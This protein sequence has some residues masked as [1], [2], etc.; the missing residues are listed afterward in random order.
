MAA[1]KR[2]ARPI[3]SPRII[4]FTR[5][6]M[7]KRH[8]PDEIRQGVRDAKAA[9]RRRPEAD[10]P[11]SRSARD[12]DERGQG[13]G[14][15]DDD[16][17]R[18]RGDHGEGLHR[19]GRDLDRALLR[20]RRRRARRRPEL[21]GR[22]ELQQRVPSLRAR[23]RTLRAGQPREAPR[24]RRADGQQGRRL[25]PDAVDLRGQPRRDPRAEP[26][27][28]PRLPAPVDGAVLEAES[29][30]PR[31]VLRRAGATRR[32]CA[33]A[34]TTASGWTRCGTSASRAA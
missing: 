10:V 2:R 4:V 32:K 17:H 18:R 28:V 24:R 19:A 9:R 21:P 20:H 34:R 33:G 27:V 3:I 8:T 15:A 26:A 11:G 23:R 29:R 6:S 16:A 22:H 7:G 30:Q 5:P 13:A 1:R 14:P 12:R 25:E 31:L